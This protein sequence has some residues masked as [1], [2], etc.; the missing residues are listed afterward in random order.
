MAPSATEE[1][2]PEASPQPCHNQPN[3]AVERF[4]ASLQTAIDIKMSRVCDKMDVIGDRLQS[5]ESRQKS[6]EEEIKNS[7]SKSESVTSSPA[8]STPGR[9]RQTPVALQVGDSISDYN[10]DN[11]DMAMAY[12]L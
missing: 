11:A 7:T 8:L 1:P 6:L 4:L 12:F 10:A 2:E 3:L 5:L 9:K